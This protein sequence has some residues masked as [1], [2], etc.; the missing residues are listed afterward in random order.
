[1]KIDLDVIDAIIKDEEVNGFS[2]CENC[3]TTYT[4]YEIENGL[5]TP[6][7]H[8]YN[9]QDCFCNCGNDQYKS[10]EPSRKG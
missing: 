1:M 6:C 8:C 3:K 7:P 4:N 9:C 5:Q 2:I 10:K